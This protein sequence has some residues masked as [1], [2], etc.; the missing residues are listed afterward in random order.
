VNILWFL[1]NL[2]PRLMNNCL[3]MVIRW[4]IKEY[5]KW[6][7]NIYTDF[8]VIRPGWSLLSPSGITSLYINPLRTGRHP[9]EWLTYSFK[10]HLHVILN[11]SLN[12][13]VTCPV[14]ETE[15]HYSLSTKIFTNTDFM[16]IKDANMYFMS[17]VHRVNSEIRNTRKGLIC[18]F[19]LLSSCLNLEALVFLFYIH[20]C[21]FVHIISICKCRKR[22]QCV[23]VIHR[24]LQSC[25]MAKD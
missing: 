17:S 24:R 12:F 6:V 19:L 22:F 16:C 2:Y 21:H 4:A 11:D 5:I 7:C 1:P 23:G 20:Y 10:I 14:G 9:H 18:G 13:E 25:N 15:F 8:I 3:I